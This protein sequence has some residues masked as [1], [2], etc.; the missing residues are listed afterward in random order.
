VGALH[1]SIDDVAGDD[2][3]IEVEAGGHGEVVEVGVRAESAERVNR[4]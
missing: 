3:E 2:Q 1:E 4:G